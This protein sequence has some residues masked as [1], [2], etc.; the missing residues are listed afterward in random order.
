MKLTTACES[1]PR[2]FPCSRVRRSNSTAWCLA[3]RLSVFHGTC[4]LLSRTFVLRVPVHAKANVVAAESSREA[5]APVQKAAWHGDA[6]CRRWL[7]S[8][9]SVVS[10]TCLRC[11]CA[12]GQTWTGT[13]VSSAG[14][15]RTGGGAQRPPRGA[16]SA[17][18]RQGGR[19]PGRMGRGDALLRRGPLT[20]TRRALRAGARKG[21][22]P[23][24]PPSRCH[25]HHPGHARVHSDAADVLLHP[26]GR[27]WNK[28]STEGSSEPCFLPPSKKN[29]ASS[30]SSLRT[31]QSTPSIDELTK[32]ACVFD[33]LG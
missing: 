9:C 7:T 1:R 17:G 15:A 21:R 10:T 8:R 3:T 25:H 20:A 16:A 22:P 2:I 19:G 27:T 23:P 6:G 18:A 26:P 29:T 13:T 12:P 28:P 4:V 31:R 33:R 30:R 11:L 32:L 24:P 14:P 5:L